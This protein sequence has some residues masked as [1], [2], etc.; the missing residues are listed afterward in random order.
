MFI[1][2][3]RSPHILWWSLSKNSRKFQKTTK[4]NGRM[5]V[6]PKFTLAKLYLTTKGRKELNFCSKNSKYYYF[7]SNGKRTLI[8]SNIITLFHVKK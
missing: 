3:K 2:L 6:S 4:I 5:K 7:E 8:P 1:N